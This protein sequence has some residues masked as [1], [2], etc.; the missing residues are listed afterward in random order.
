MTPK[1]AYLLKFLIDCSSIEVFRFNKS[2][3]YK[4]CK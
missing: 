3:K 4:V 1:Q 2:I